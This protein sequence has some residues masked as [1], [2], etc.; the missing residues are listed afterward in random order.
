M[1]INSAMFEKPLRTDHSVAVRPRL[2]FN[3]TSAPAASKRDTISSR[4]KTAARMSAV[5]P[6]SELAFTSVPSASKALTTSASPSAAARINERVSEIRF[7]LLSL[8]PVRDHRGECILEAETA[9]I[10]QKRRPSRY[11]SCLTSSIVSWG[12]SLHPSASSAMDRRGAEVMGFKFQVS[13]FQ[14]S[15]S[16][17]LHISRNALVYYVRSIWQKAVSSRWEQRSTS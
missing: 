16:S 3:L 15:P 2:S 6:R 1:A 12:I 7:A 11:F 13:T 4:P 5:W 14:I 17:H 9:E 10:Y 8:H